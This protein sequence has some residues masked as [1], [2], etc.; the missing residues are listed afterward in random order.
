LELSR[1]IN[2]Y[3]GMLFSLITSISPQF[4]LALERALGGSLKYLIVDDKKA[5]K[6]VSSL[7][8][9]KGYLRTILTLK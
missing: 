1:L 9:D 4:T 2:G 6:L 3:H 5:T 7:L 8:K